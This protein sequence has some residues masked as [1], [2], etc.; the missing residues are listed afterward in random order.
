MAKN[1]KEDLFSESTMSFGDHLEELR[2]C[3]FR[4]MIGLLIGVG[5]GIFVAK[6]FVKEIQEPLKD[7]LRGY[8]QQR[9]FDLVRTDGFRHAETAGMIEDEGYSADTMEI[10]IDQL[11]INLRQSMP[12]VF[13]GLQYKSYMFVEQDF[14]IEDDGISNHRLFFQHI[15]SHAKQDWACLL[16][17]SPSPRD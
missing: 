6:D 16:N 2:Q 11:F 7:A 17:T 3:L 4:G 8:Y 14:L 5:F 12:Q 1:P 15:H 10:E 13:E 9:S